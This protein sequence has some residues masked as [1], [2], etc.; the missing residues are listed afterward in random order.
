MKAT[1]AQ[2][3]RD[4][5]QEPFQAVLNTGDNFYYCGIQNLDDPNISDDYITPYQDKNW[6]R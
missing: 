2:M 6:T 4:Y 5:N 1:A 3:K